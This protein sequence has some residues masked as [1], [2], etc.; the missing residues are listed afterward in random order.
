MKFYKRFPADIEIKTGHLTPAERG[1][2][3]R[4]LDHY[5]ARERA[6]P[7]GKAYSVCRAVDKSDKAACDRVLAEFFE[8]TADGWVQARA[9]EEIAD[10]LPRIEASRQNGKLGGRPRKPTG[11]SEGNLDDDDGQT[12]TG[13]L[14]KGSQSLDSS[15]RSESPPTPPRGGAF[16]GWWSAWPDRATKMAEDQ[17]RRRWSRDRLDERAS[18]VIAAL[19]RDKASE[20]WRK[21]HGA[22]IPAPLTWLRQKR[23]LAPTT[24]S[25]GQAWHETRSGIVAKGVELSLGEWDEYAASVGQGLQWTE[26]QARVFRAAGY[27]P[28]RAA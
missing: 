3:D 24:D 4:L 23:W 16:D 13:D 15:L 11:F 12:Q 19:E 8:L 21:D 5:Y 26:Y 25:T 9:E 22:Y 28:R 7:A 6:I 27:V 1:C 18:E 17:C 2:Y 14:R 20:T 10:A